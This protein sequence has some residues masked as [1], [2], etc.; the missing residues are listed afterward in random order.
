MPATKTEQPPQGDYIS[1][2]PYPGMIVPAGSIPPAGFQVHQ[3]EGGVFQLGLLPPEGFDPM[4]AKKLRDKVDD[5]WNKLQ[6]TEDH[7]NRHP[8]E[9]LVNPEFRKVI[10]HQRHWGDNQECEL[11]LTKDDAYLPKGRPAFRF[12][13]TEDVEP[14]LEVDAE[15]LEQDKHQMGAV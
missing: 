9:M 6:P 4:V 8:V 7:P 15:A 3:M 14:A 12:V 5:K 1:Q 2:K 10:K 11:I 13:T